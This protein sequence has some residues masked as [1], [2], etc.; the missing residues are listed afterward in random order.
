MA[1]EAEIHTYRAPWTVYGLAWCQRKGGKEAYRLAIGSF[2]ED[3][4][5]VVQI[6]QFDPD[7]SQMSAVAELSHPYPTTKIEWV[8]GASTKDVIATSGDYLRLWNLDADNSLQLVKVLNNTKSREFCAPLTS[9]DW[10]RNDSHI[11]GT[12]SIDTTCTIWDIEYDAKA[13]QL[14]AHDKEVYDISFANDTHRFAS[15]GA[16]GSVRMFDRRDLSHSTITYESKDLTPLLR[17]EWNRQDDYFIAALSANAN[18]AIIL[19]TRM[20]AIPVAELHTHTAPVNAIAWAPHSSCH[21]CTASDDHLSLIWDLSSIPKTVED[22]LLSYKAD[23]PIDQMKWSSSL[24]DWIAISFGDH[25]QLL[26]V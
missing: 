15:V 3:F 17:V 2:I 9:F 4:T 24:N 13:T 6:I 14:I 21:I 12:S 7:T 11:L 1:K 5:N 20:P 25:L 23:G 18:H 8:P 26:K 16:D 10:N 22:P 19:D